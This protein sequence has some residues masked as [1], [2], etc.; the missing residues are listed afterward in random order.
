MG[1]PGSQVFGD[2]FRRDLVRQVYQRWR[3]SMS[4]PDLNR[5]SSL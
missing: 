5:A 2:G 4:V 1:L 3:W